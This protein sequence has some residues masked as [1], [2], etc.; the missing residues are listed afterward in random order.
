MAG[1]MGLTVVGLWQLWLLFWSR[2]PENQH[3]RWRLAFFHLPAGLFLGFIFLLGY[4]L[5]F[6]LIFHFNRG[7][8]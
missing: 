4:D 2:T 8:L 1:G 6:L 7:S 3:L 5:R